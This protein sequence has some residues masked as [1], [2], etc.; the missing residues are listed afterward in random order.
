VA[1]SLQNG[2]PA[3]RLAGL[4]VLLVD[5]SREVLETLKMLL[6]MEDAQVID[7]SEPHR[8]LEAARTGQFD[9]V[10]S[11]IGMPNMSGHDLMRALRELPHIRQIPVIALTGYGAESDIDKSRQS[12]FDRHLGKP[13]SYDVLIDTI[14]ELRQA[15]TD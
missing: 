5:D 11:D 6:E 12:G 3:G 2:E 15:R 4:T 13:V 14:E 8:A 10:V 1:L 9:V 7:F